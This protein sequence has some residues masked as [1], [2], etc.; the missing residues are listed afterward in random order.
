M[1]VLMF[2]VG[3]VSA[4]ILETTVNEVVVKTDKNGKEYVRLIIPVTKTESGI[5]WDDTLPAMV[6][7]NGSDTSQV[8][9]AKTLKPGDKIKCAVKMR[10]YEGREYY[11]I[12]KFAE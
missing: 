1:F 9:Y 10:K 3:A 2:A 12:L 11:T 6:F 8:E 7:S 5:T 4:E